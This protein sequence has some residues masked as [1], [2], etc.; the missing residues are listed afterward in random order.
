M[1]YVIIAASDKAIEDLI[2]TNVL[3]SESLKTLRQNTT[4]VA[5]KHFIQTIPGIENTK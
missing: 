4:I 1:W 2:A 3:E 5:K